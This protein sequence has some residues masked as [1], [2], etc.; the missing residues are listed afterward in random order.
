MID[1]K[2][3]H[4]YWWNFLLERVWVPEDFNREIPEVRLT[5]RLSRT[6][7]RANCVWAEYNLNFVLQEGDKYDETICHEVCHCF[8]NRLVRWT[9]HGS[10]WA[11]IYNEVC[12]ATR[13]RYHSYSKP[14]KTEAVEAIKEMMRLQ[15][16]IAACKNQE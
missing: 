6:A 3:R 2:E 1:V 11:Y 16:K 8:A 15:K 5:T 7:G 13:G 9:K 12:A 10:L 14:V 4:A